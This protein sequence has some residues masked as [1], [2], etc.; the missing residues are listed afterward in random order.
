MLFASAWRYYLPANPQ[1]DGGLTLFPQTGS[2]YAVLS[3]AQPGPSVRTL[4]FADNGTTVEIAVGQRLRTDLGRD[5]IWRFEVDN[6]QVLEPQ[7]M[8][9][10]FPPPPA[11]FIGRARGETM[12]RAAGEHPCRYASP[13]CLAPPSGEAPSVL[14]QVRV[15][16]R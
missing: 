10:I 5:R 9:L 12:V 3:L 1:I 6:P 14:W 8:I 16:V 13:P 15:I 2:A 7:P 11:E 4:T